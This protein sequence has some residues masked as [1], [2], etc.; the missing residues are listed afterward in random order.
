MSHQM[1]HPII[2][3]LGDVL[4][5]IV[6]LKN[7]SFT[8]SEILNFMALNKQLVA[9]TETES[10]SLGLRMNRD[11]CHIKYFVQWNSWVVMARDMVANYFTLKP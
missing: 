4:Q 9:I 7:L 1:K 10:F 6:L 2:T 3:E 11:I 5:Q 8:V